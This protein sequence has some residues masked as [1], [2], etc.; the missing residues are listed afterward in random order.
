MK[1]L[2]FLIALLMAFA[3]AA[4]AQDI[5][6]DLSQYDIELRHSFTGQELLLFGAIKRGETMAGERYDIVIV[7]TGEERPHMVR[8]KERVMGFWVN[9]GGKLL[10][11]VPE[12]YALAST[13]PLL[14]IAPEKE[15]ARL[16][17][18]LAQQ[19]F[20]R[21]PGLE[22]YAAGLIRVKQGAGLY[23]VA[24]EA[25]AL[26][27]ETLFRADFFFPANVPSGA[28]TAS[29]YLFR[30]GR[31][32]GRSDK[33]IRIGKA[34]FERV[35]YSLAQNQPHLYGLMAI[36]IALLAGWLA[37]FITRPKSRLG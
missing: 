34:G 37:G 17:I 25:M 10:E 27:S 20:A 18:G 23:Q 5:V 8:K 3:P 2:V 16:K 7:I 30:E 12:Y 26:Q 36:I 9:T 32:I 33:E 11:G 28:Y 13:R 14:A 35:V 29:A 15:L 1:R 24:T 21:Q 4:R 19:D 22:D 6:T 31:L